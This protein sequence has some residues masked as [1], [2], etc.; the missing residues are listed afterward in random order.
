MILKADKP[1]L[2]TG[3]ELNA[4][5]QTKTHMRVIHIMS[6]EGLRPKAVSASEGDCIEKEGK[7]KLEDE[8]VVECES[9]RF[10]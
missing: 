4:R 6:D 8:E 2:P 1:Q 3:A 10:L 7:R 9:E 5:L